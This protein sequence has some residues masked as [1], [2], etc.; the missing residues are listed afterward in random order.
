MG[1]RTKLAISAKG[2]W[3]VTDGRKIEKDKGVNRGYLTAKIKGTLWATKKASVKFRA[4]A[5]NGE[6]WRGKKG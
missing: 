4:T 5:G 1:F 6:S 2:I 3:E